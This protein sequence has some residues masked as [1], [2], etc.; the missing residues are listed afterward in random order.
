MPLATAAAVATFLW[1]GWRRQRRRVWRGYVLGVARVLVAA[2]ARA[3][4]GSLE[5]TE[6]READGEGVDEELQSLGEWCA[7]VVNLARRP[8][9]LQQVEEL[10]ARS[11]PRLLARLERVEAV[12]G[13]LLRLDDPALEEVV[14]ARALERAQRAKSLGI[15]SVVHDDANVLVHFDDHLTEG[16]IACAMSHRRALE[17]VASHPTA[18]WGLILEDDNSVVVPD[19]DRAIARLL[20]KL[21]EDW[22]AVYLG[23]H[24]D[25]GRPH[26]AGLRTAGAAKPVRSHALA[27]EWAPAEGSPEV[28]EV[29]VQEVRSHCW[30]LF[31]WMVKKDVARRLVD[32]LFP[33]RSQVDGAV[34]GWLVRTCGPERVFCVPPEQ[35]FFYS[36]CSEEGQDSDIQTMV[37]EHAV[38]EEYGT[39]QAYKARTKAPNPYES[40]GLEDMLAMTRG[41]FDRE[42][43]ASEAGFDTAVGRDCFP[44]ED[45]HAMSA[46]DLAACRRV[47]VQR[48]FGAFTVFHGQAYF[49]AQPPAA[50]AG[51]LEEAEGATCYVRRGRGAADGGY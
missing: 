50:C 39:L 21:P 14:E 43:E 44:G 15:Y 9:R 34:S 25:D 10:L 18:A 28:V 3:R 35:L 6:E 20:R 24:H 23:Y 48:G 12:D 51:A 46:A 26:P 16:A 40:L 30:G 49:R 4:A 29:P 31:A 36:S 37:S 2:G 22:E 17:R 42:E 33:I 13:R 11:N 19:V 8:D 41:I 7:L 38:L 47:C 5:T 1:R 27:S 45:A 32:E